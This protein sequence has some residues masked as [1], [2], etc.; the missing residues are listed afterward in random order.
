M[1]ITRTYSAGDKGRVR[2]LTNLSGAWVDVSPAN[3]LVIPCFP[4]EFYDV[5]TDITDPNKVYVGG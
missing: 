2:R 5:E 3:N 4:A 1:N